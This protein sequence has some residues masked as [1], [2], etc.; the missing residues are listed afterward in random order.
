MS[1]AGALAGA[2]LVGG[3][4]T[5]VSGQ[6]QVNAAAQATAA[7]SPA[8]STGSSASSPTGS[9]ESGGSSS[10]SSATGLTEPSTSGTPVPPTSPG[11]STH[12][13][14]TKSGPS[15]LS[16][17]PGLSAD[18]NKVLAGVQAFTALFD[19]IS[20]SGDMNAK[21]TQASVDAALKALPASGLPPAVQGDVTT[22]RSWAG[23]AAGKSMTELAMS[24]TD[25]KVTTA[26]T[27]LS[28]WLTTNCY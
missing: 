10:T 4:A 26:I 14:I 9:T 16:S 17:V 5:T 2:L 20:S 11:T 24:L 28:T 15:S 19:Q 6:A 21:V 18:C 23:G 8:T 3:C 22:L 12:G 13:T 27:N 1:V 7:S 25:G